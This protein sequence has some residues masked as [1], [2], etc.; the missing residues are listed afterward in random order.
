MAPHPGEKASR[1]KS[2]KLK[3]AADNEHDVDEEAADHP[4]PSHLQSRKKRLRSLLSPFKKEELIDLHVQIGTKIPAAA[5]EIRDAANANP[6]NRRLCVRF[7]NPT[8]T[9]E[10]LCAAFSSFGEIQ[11][12][13]VILERKTGES[14]CFGFITF[15]D[16]ESAEEALETPPKKIDGYV[17][18]C[19]HASDRW[20]RASKIICVSG[21]PPDVSAKTLRSHFSQYGEV[22][23]CEV[24]YKS[25]TKKS[26]GYGFVTFKTIGGA[27]RANRPQK[28]MGENRIYVRYSDWK[29]KEPKIPRIMQSESTSESTAPP[30]ARPSPPLQ[31]P[32][33]PSYVAGAYYGPYAFAGPHHFGADEAHPYYGPYAIVGPHHFGANEAHPYYGPYAI[34]GHRYVGGNEAYGMAPWGTS[35]YPYH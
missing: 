27:M 28:F 17:I 26:K 30:P 25:K 3:L 4:E 32:L 5:K 20:A 10:T 1:R 9:T 18:E 21:L 11:R 31:P 19:N 12:G 2:E 33:A 24:K 15:K 22:K 29:S 6:Q 35:G 8:T 23:K 14:R 13:L 16:I 34:A 7:L